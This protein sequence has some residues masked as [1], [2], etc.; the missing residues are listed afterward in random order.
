MANGKHTG[1][2]IKRKD[3]KG[4]YVL[5]EKLDEGAEGEIYS[6]ANSPQRVVK[7]YKPGKAPKDVQAQKLLA[8]EGMMPPLSGERTGHPSLTWP[9]EIIQDQ[10]KNL[11]GFVMPRVDI[12][13]TMKAGLF[14]IPKERQKKLLEMNAPSDSQHIQNTTWK[15]IRN[16]SK[17]MA[18]VHEQGHL[19][20][21]INARNI[22]V[23]PQ[24][25]DVS[26]I[27][28][29][30]FQIRDVKN[31]VIYRCKVGRPEYTAPELLRQ[32]Q[33]EC[34]NPSCPNW[35][36]N[37]DMG[38]P[39]V[40][41]GQQHD[42]FGLAVIA[43]QLLMDGSHPYDC[44]IDEAHNAEANSCEKKIIRNYFPYSVSKPSYIH[45]NNPRNAKR[46]SNLP[47]KAKDSFERSFGRA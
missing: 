22:L 46:Y 47:K 32:M 16:L 31:R 41:R 14:F 9:E 39:C 40:E 18:R 38:Y 42:E 3:N 35:P 26:I 43:F 19:I 23:E 28:C 17:I 30:S 2:K 36:T 4:H 20:G 15:I 45:V 7:V 10:N 34:T 27:D 8:M 12:A 13:R 29:D 21:D 44:R 25:G 37:H 33:G 1:T 11:V 24:H 5:G 6:V